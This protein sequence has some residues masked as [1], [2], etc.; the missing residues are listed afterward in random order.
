MSRNELRAQIFAAKEL[1]REIITFFGAEIELRQPTLGDILTVRDSD[2][3]QAAVVGILMNYAYVP[4]SD[5]KV[6][7]EGDAAT[8]LEM[9]WNSD[10]TKLNSAL[11]RLTDINFNEGADAS[12]KTLGATS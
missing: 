2:D 3:R 11:E 7:E 9:P 1:K 12:K 10:F 8:I 5:E 4:G 6:F